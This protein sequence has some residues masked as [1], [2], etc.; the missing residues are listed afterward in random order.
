MK[1]K[2]YTIYVEKMGEKK[3]TSLNK[4]ENG[5]SLPLHVKIGETTA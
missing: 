2:Y 5:R 4:G 1:Y 3:P